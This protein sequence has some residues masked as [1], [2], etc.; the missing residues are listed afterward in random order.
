MEATAWPRGWSMYVAET[1]ERRRPTLVSRT[2]LRG[3][4]SAS[5]RATVTMEEGKYT[6]VIC[7]AVK[8]CMCR[9]T[10]YNVC[11]HKCISFILMHTQSTHVKCETLRPGHASASGAFV[12]KQ[13]GLAATIHTVLCTGR[14]T[15]A[16]DFRI[17][18][19]GISFTCTL[20][21]GQ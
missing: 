14:L 3:T 13:A 16:N 6:N 9:H 2:A 7:C 15:S 1:P 17:E 5:P 10:V 21:K 8:L 18:Q 4:E 11:V 12:Q 20:C 19:T